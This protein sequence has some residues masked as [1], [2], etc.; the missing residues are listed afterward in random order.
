MSDGRQH[1]KASVHLHAEVK[2]LANDYGYGIAEF[3]DLVLEYVLCDLAR[4]EAAIQ[5]RAK[6]GSEKA[7]QR[8]EPGVAHLASRKT[9]S[10]A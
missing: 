8:R 9:D 10:T 3:T 1:L 7:R 5:E 6:R 2:N 4:I